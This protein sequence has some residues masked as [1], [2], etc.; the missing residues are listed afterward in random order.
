[1]I[2]VTFLGT[3]GSAPTKD[4]GL[5][6]VAVT[7]EGD[8]LLFDCG[9]G[10][11]RQMLNYG[12]NI[13]RIKS[14]FI[15]HMHGDHV[16]GVAGLVRTL[17][18]NHRTEPL[19]IFVPKGSEKGVAA[20]MLFDNAL[21]NYPV[22]INGVSAGIVYK[23]KGFVVRAFTL[24]HTVKTYGYSLAEDDRMRFDTEKCRRYGIN[25]TMFS[26][27]LKNKQIR[28]GRKT[29][30]LDEVAHKVK[31]LKIVYSTDTRPVAST[32]A[33]SKDADLLIHEASF[34]EQ[35][36]RLA[37]ERMHSTAAEAAQIAKK[38]RVK[39]LVLFHMSARY[40][41]ADVLQDEARRIFKNT[42]VAKDGMQIIL[43]GKKGP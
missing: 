26:T 5:P 27:L 21:I 10:A 34:G 19:N 40:R 33:E 2:K 20:L 35:L 11:Q 23:G 37:A 22:I 43:G 12:I 39:E 15:T 18:L 4:R 25:G 28:V 31:G 3:S 30:R 24:K 9:E 13:S 16:I 36:K 1:M 41:N 6:S 8:T 32:V 38:A 14:I 42:V 7:Y 17:A 29:V